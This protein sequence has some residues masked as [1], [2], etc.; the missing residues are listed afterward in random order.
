MVIGMLIKISKVYRNKLKGILA[1][2][3]VFDFIFFSM[4][5]MRTT[6]T[7]FI[8]LS[9]TVLLMPGDDTETENTSAL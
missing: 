5:E 4:L 7:F 9:L 6:A 2:F 8:V 1:R 3:L